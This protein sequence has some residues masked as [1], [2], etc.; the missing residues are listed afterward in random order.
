M[1]KGKKIVPKW[2]FPEFTECGEWEEKTLGEIG[3]PLMCKRIF[4]EQTFS[5]SSPDGVPF[6]KIGT[7]GKV[8][9]SYISVELFEEYKSKYPFPKRGE[10]L[11]SA[12][13]TIGRL[14]VYDGMP[15]FFQDSNI[16]WLS[17]DENK[18]LNRF[19]FYCY[20]IMR[21]KTS[22][23][24]VIRRL[25]NSDFKN[26]KINFPCNPKEQQKIA[27]FLSSVDDL[28]STEERK[29]S[30]LGDH[31]KGWMQRLF[32][33]E[34]KTTPEWRFPEFRDSGEWKEKTLGEIVSYNG[35][36]LSL[37]KL[38][39]KSEG[40]PVYGADGLVGYI[41]TYQQNEKYIS[42]VKDGSVG[43]L[44][45]NTAYSSILGT[46]SCLQSTDKSKYLLEWIYYYLSSVDFSVYVKGSAIPHIYY[47]DY[48]NMICRVPDFL[49]QQKIADF[50][51]HIDVFTNKQTNKIEALRQHKKALM[52]GLFPNVEEV[53]NGA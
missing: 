33:A 8:A 51:S 29:L 31:K 12:S 36:T 40:Y 41:D 15:A 49:E 17:N 10:I 43:K 32:P 6:Y 52:Q 47:S 18:V 9:D 16:V 39:L 13:G 24:G 19:L 50:L 25:Y 35:S 42:M 48:K 38:E 23:G 26:M 3:N 37:N 46:L 20:S 14:V 4:K 22:D 1:S 45:L 11:I 44:N 27:D 21:W 7:F 30:L 53:L 28:I 2:R 5:S 34:G